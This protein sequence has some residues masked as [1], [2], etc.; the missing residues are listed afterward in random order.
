MVGQ[1][2]GWDLQG[3][4]QSVGGEVLDGEQ[5]DHCETRRI[6]EGRENPRPIL[7]RS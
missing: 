3:C 1:E 7:T 2:I 4:R 6:T 5:L